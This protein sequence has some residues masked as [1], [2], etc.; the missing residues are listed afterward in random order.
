MVQMM[1]TAQSEA[2]ARAY[3]RDGAASVIES[4]LGE[5]AA[6]AK[7]AE[8]HVTFVLQSL[9]AMAEHQVDAA[10][11]LMIALYP[12]ADELLMHDVCD[13][14][15]LWVWHNQSAVVIE[16]LKRS[17]ASEPDPDL[18]RHLEGMLPVE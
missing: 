14:I 17:A 16:H 8:K 10:C 4:L 7:T 9:E 1:T 5:A 13:S 18:K 2:L 3:A 11:C 12:V 15:G 6:G